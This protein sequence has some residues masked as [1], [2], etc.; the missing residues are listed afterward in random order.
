MISQKVLKYLIFL[1]LLTIACSLNSNKGFTQKATPSQT[2][3][4]SIGIEAIK[5]AI[6]EKNYSQLEKLLKSNPNLDVRDDKNI[7][8]LQET[9]NFDLKSAE[10]LLQSGANPDFESLAIGCETAERCLKSPIVIAFEKENIDVLRLLLKY[11]ADPNKGSILAGAVSRSYKEIVNLLISHKADVNYSK[12][13][14]EL[15]QTPI[16]FA[17]TEEIANI[18]IKN[19]ANINKVDEKGLTP[20]MYAV[21]NQ[22][23][24]LIQTL[25]Q[26]KVDVNF[27]NQNGQTA[28][29]LAKASTNKAIIKLLS[30]AGAK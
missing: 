12:D 18:L 30:K 9:L 24:K 19:G 28:L 13:F 23:I 6:K 11:S 1:S 8:L 29:G 14:G 3:Q 5:N 22:N 17:E 16:F 25:L 26:N 2:E 7:S 27:T 10:M 20:L 21:Q 15:G 4:K